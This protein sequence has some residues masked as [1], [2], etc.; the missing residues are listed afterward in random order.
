MQCGQLVITAANGKQSIDTVTVTIGGKT[1]T[2]VN[3]TASIQT[4]ID[5]AS[6]GDML[7]IDPATRA[8]ATGTTLSFVPA[9]HTEILLMWKPVRLQGVGAVASVLNANTHPAGKI[10]VWRRQVN[11]LF[12]LSLSGYQATSGNP[13]DPTGAYTCARTANFGAGSTTLA[14]FQ[15]TAAN[16]QVDRLPLEAVV[17]WNASLNGNLAELLQEPS[18]MGALEGAAITVLSKGVQ[19]PANATDI[20]GANAA[21]AGVFPAGTVLLDGSTNAAHGCGPNTATGPNPFPSNFYCNPSSIDGLTVENASQ[22]GGGIF[23]HGWG[24]NLQ[25]ANNRVTNNMGTMSGGINVGQ[26]EFPGAYTQG[27][28]ALNADPGSCRTTA[29]VNAAG[30]QLPYCFDINVN[31]HHNAVTKNSST[32]DEL[33]SATPA[34]AGGVS[35][36]NGSDFYKF[37]YNWLCGNLSTGD[38]GGLGH[39]GY[40]YNGDIEHN[41]IL[42]NQSANPTIPT[43]GGG[44]L[45][46]GAPD[47]D[48]TCG[49]V[50]DLDCL[51][52]PPVAPGDGVGPGL[53]INANLIQGNA[54]ESGSGGGVRF[55]GVNGTDVLT[56][57]TIPANWY[58]VL[59]TNNLINN[60]VAGW[61]GAGISLYDSLD[62]DIVNN[63]I[64][65]NDT[66]AS[67]GVLFNTVGAPLASSQGPCTGPR[68]PDGTCPN[69]VIASTHQPA[70]I[71]AIPHS[72][73]MTTN[74]PNPVTCPAGH[75][76]GTNANNADCRTVSY[77][78]LYNN[79]IFQNRVFNIAVGALGIGAQNQQNVVTLVPALNQPT[80][81]ATTGNGG[82]VIVTGGTG[83]C[84]TTGANGTGPVSYWD[85]GVRGDTGPDNHASGVTLTPSY[86]VLTDVSG[87]SG[88]GA[89]GLHNTGSNPTV[90]R[91][92]C[93]GSRV[94]PENGGLGYN[95]PAGIAD[96]TV[97]NP[98]FNLTP[99]ATVD[100]GNNWINIAWGPLSLVN[101]SNGTQNGVTLGNYGPAA[102][103][104]AINYIPAT[105]AGA[106]NYAAAPNLD[107][108]GNTRKNG[109]VDAGAV[110]FAGAA[111]VAALNVTPTS[112]AFGNQASGTTSATQNLTL[113]NTGS[114]GASGIGVAITAPFTRITTG[115]F[116]GGAPNCVATLAAG[117]NCTIKVAFAPTTT[118]PANGTATI[119]ANVTV[120]GSP[121]TLT[122]TGVA[123]VVAATLAPASWT[124]TATRG[125]TATGSTACPA[126]AFTLTNTGNVT[127]TGILQGTVTGTNAS[128]F[129]VN[130]LTS[131]C[132][133]SGNG[134]SLGQTTL[135][136]GATC[137]IT[138][139]FAPPTGDTA[140][141]K[142]ATVSVTDAAGTQSSSLIGTAN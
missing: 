75:F 123:P 53:V 132:G 120:S 23:V 84:V 56:F 12:G 124:T 46:M 96:A 49:L 113:H 36:C 77:P 22:G 117:A 9:I 28:G 58:R 14:A 127:L 139:R 141:A 95:V 10:D 20:F 115:T 138:V 18:L 71:V 106:A 6:P 29:Y 133:P 67:S 101:T 2:H 27:A 59:V 87:A 61:D 32:G 122:G 88:Y 94:P 30:A 16:P 17:G 90:L 114:A 31:I 129:P 57:P 125:C 78:L 41:S 50:N 80:A 137:T 73:M 45:V 54:A 51:S 83:A 103:S 48:P 109:F 5:N 35:L 79:V 60:N 47:V 108:Y 13:Y 121:V 72:S 3:P 107:F 98:I 82:G 76:S 11:C 131:T 100:E 92:Y 42:F 34:G 1:P 63:T 66:T 128:D 40:S 64:M 104:P 65:S 86:S 37:N 43:N 21:T 110:E 8:S 4:A 39:I 134:Q 111:A 24:H 89:A 26:G 93:N 116:P 97:P 69:P 136:P 38:G 55:Q 68:N 81:D 99:A 15:P 62:V 102:G 91:Q 112:L 25:I 119:T 44:I 7:M 105:G 19:I 85:L 142:N 70:G 140:G 52:T 130:R 126:Q 74:M 118:G 135:T 33:F